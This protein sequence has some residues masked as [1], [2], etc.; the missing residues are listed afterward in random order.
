MFRALRAYNYRVYFLGGLVSNTGT[1]VQRIAQDWLVLQLTGGSGT[2]L[3][4]TTALQFLPM[5]LFGLWA[6][7]L[8]DRY[9][10]RRVLA[11]ANAA[12]GLV[13]LVLGVLVLTGAVQVWHVFVLAFLLGT[14]SAVENPTRQSFVVEMVGRDDLTNA[15]GLNSAS[16][17]SARVVGPAAAGVLIAALGDETGP[18]FLLNAASY[19]AVI[20]ALRA[21]RPGEL[22]P[23]PR[24][25]RGPGQVR[26]GLRY[27]AGR[28]D[29]LLVLLVVFFVGTFGLNFQITNALMATQEFGRGSEAYGLLGSVMAVGSLSGALLAARRRAPSLALLVGG[30]L[31]FALLVVA[32]GLMPTYALFAVSLVPVGVVSLTVITT[33]NA[34][35]QLGVD[36]LVRGRVMALYMVVFFGGT[37]VGAP[38][39][40]ALAEAVGPRASL[41]LGGVAVLVGVLGSLLVLARRPGVAVAA[42]LGRHPALTVSA[43]PERARPGPAR[44]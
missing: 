29:L 37:P 32:S 24:T 41:V 19:A 1:W 3:G 13:A 12:M 17:N 25:P 30:S 44:A 11:V 35:L 43:A 26:E 5:P 27:V 39:V 4:V 16:F 40:G 28:P 42:R 34:S 21:M 31:V 36:P 6:G 20:L 8:A 22:Q 33:A 23:A 15:V 7:T 14:G 10:K 18:L 2:A 38:L 9:P